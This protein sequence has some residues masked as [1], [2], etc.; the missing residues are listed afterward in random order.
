M[1]IADI[2]IA[3]EPPSTT[4]SDPYNPERP[5]VLETFLG[6]PV[7]LMLGIITIGAMIYFKSTKKNE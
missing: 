6:N 2:E 1:H 4:I 5:T 7:V 3:T